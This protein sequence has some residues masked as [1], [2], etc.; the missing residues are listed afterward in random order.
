[1]VVSG[2]AVSISRKVLDDLNVAALGHPQQDLVVRVT[3][4]LILGAV[5]N[6]GCHI[7]CCHL[8]DLQEN[9]FVTRRRRV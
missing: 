2:W 7:N 1:V 3:N 4:G 9:R 5:D 8:F 6:A